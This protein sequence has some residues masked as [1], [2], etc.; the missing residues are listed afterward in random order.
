MAQ[1]SSAQREPSMEE[2]LASIR[3]IIEDSDTV[4][5]PFDEAGTSRLSLSSHQG[6]IEQEV[7]A[8]RA[9]L[10]EAG[11]EPSSAA[12][13]FT[14]AAEESVQTP[15]ETQESSVTVTAAAGHSVTEERASVMPRQPDESAKQFERSRSTRV[16]GAGD[17]IV[18]DGAVMTASSLDVV[19]AGS[20]SAAERNMRTSPATSAVAL[21]IAKPD[22]DASPA[23]PVPH[24]APPQVNV[25]QADA[26]STL[27]GGEEATSADVRPALISDQAG[28]QVAAAFGEL[29]EA[30][31]ASRRRSFDEM[32]EE[33]LRP[34]LQDW[35]DNNLPTLVERLVREEIERVARGG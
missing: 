28:R 11:N 9:G 23:G 27:A 2:I 5:Q 29:S 25:A 16:T 35:L 20:H 15:H 32:A 26:S 22:S 10:D 31:A 33:M 24:N 12:D 14:P 18:E 1:T 17:A 3:R 19:P 4:R 30:F 6:E 21:E 34:M 8:F 7:E 13:G